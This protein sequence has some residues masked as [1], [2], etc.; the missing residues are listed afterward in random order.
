[1]ADFKLRM[2]LYPLKNKKVIYDASKDSSVAT[3]SMTAK[4]ARIARELLK[5]ARMLC[6]AG[7][8]AGRTAEIDDRLRFCGIRISDV[9]ARSSEAFKQIKEFME[10]RIDGWCEQKLRAVSDPEVAGPLMA[11]DADVEKAERWLKGRLDEFRAGMRRNDA[12]GNMAE[13][14]VFSMLAGLDCAA[15]G[16]RTYPIEG[17]DINWK[18]YLGSKSWPMTTQ[19]LLDA[20]CHAW[21]T[22][23]EPKLKDDDCDWWGHFVYAA[24]ETLSDD[25]MMLSPRERQDL[26]GRACALIEMA[27]DIYSLAMESMD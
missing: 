26:G 4:N 15:S 12:T 5:I 7:G 24:D 3:G 16:R 9:A 10:R 20:V 8:P 17:H 13:G 18:P 11:D 27:L 19:G 14:I 2:P 25:Y 22:Q 1:M 21:Q 6:A 23:L